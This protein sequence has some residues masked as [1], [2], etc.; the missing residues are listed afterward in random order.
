MPTDSSQPD[1]AA[2]T[3]EQALKL[4]KAQG[5]RDYEGRVLGG[6]G[7]PMVDLDR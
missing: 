4:F 6:L 2:E 3:W 1:V 5:K 7:K